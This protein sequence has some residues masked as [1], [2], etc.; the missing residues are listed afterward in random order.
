MYLLF[1]AQEQGHPIEDL[2]ES[3]IR[4]IPTTRF[5]GLIDTEQSEDGFSEHEKPVYIKDNEFSEDSSFIGT[6]SGDISYQPLATG[7][8]SAPQRPD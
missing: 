1:C 8:P 4:K 3:K 5:E 6:L 2:Y 7:K